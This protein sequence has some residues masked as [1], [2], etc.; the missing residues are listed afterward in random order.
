MI[1]DYR[2]SFLLNRESNPLYWVHE[3][4]GSNIYSSFFHGSAGADMCV[5]QDR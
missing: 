5:L 1:S 3:D 2:K 4:G